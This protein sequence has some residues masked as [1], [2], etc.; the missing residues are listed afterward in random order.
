MSRY[1]WLITFTVFVSGC[2]TTS[3]V[4][5]NI[6]LGMSPQ[7]V[8]SAAGKPFSRNLMKDAEGNGIEE[9]TYR[10]TIWDD[11]G[12]SWDKT[13]IN[14]VVTF[15]NGKVEKFAK[16]DDE[17]HKTKNPMNP[18]VNVDATVHHD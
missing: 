4:A 3:R 7:E 9:W 5:Q 1:G 16:V 18:G 14:S 13:I 12:W 2:A 15:K 11:G 6:S 17:R 10:E 8:Q